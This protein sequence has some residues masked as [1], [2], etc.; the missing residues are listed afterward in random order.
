MAAPHRAGPPHLQRC[1]GQRSFAVGSHTSADKARCQNMPGIAN[2]RG[3]LDR[4]SPDTV[5]RVCG[6]LPSP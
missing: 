3:E 1:V 6:N 5:N 4:L 2:R